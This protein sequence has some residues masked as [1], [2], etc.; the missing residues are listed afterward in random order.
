MA[1]AFGIGEEELPAYTDELEESGLRQTLSQAEQEFERTVSGVTDRGNPYSFAALGWD[2]VA[3]LY[4]LI[5]VR[6]PVV[7]VETGV[8]NGVSSAAMLQALERNREGRLYSIDLPEHS[9]T[10]YPAG[11]FWEGKMGAA[12]PKGREP[13]WIVPDELRE[14][15]DLT[16][17]R[18]QDE[19]EPLLDRLGEIDFFLHD[20]EHSYECMRFELRAAHAKL[21]PGGILASDDTNWNRA[22][23]EVVEEHGLDSFSLGAG[24]R[25][26]VV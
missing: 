15:W 18:T 23:Q 25:F 19:L 10:S 7:L 17:G 3:R 24:L 14:R 4:A 1:K 5:R 26:A 21:R 2:E 22:F 6:R 9:E 16:L 12:V 8:C 13:G 20:S 11:T